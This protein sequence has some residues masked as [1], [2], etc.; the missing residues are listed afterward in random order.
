MKS[1]LAVH[2]F[3][4][5]HPVR[6]ESTALRLLGLGRPLTY[7]R[8]VIFSCDH[9][10]GGFVDHT[11]HLNTSIHQLVGPPSPSIVCGSSSDP[12]SMLASSQCMSALAAV[13]RCGRGSSLSSSSSSKEY[14]GHMA[15][16]VAAV[17]EAG[18]SPSPR[19][20]AFFLLRLLDGFEVF[21]ACYTWHFCS[22]GGCWTRRPD[23]KKGGGWVI[24]EY[25]SDSP[26]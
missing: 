19:V 21:V 11:V 18:P 7:F 22:F 16:S 3:P 20:A 4:E 25:H 15:S 6:F 5:P 26:K 1:C 17:S 10:A 12:S 8:Y 23:R 24:T 13:C 9:A 2:S 14:P